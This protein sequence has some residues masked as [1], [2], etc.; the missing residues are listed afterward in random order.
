MAY[1]LWD[2]S[3][4]YIIPGTRTKGTFAQMRI[5]DVNRQTASKQI[6]ALLNKKHARDLRG[7]H[8]F[9]DHF[10]LYN[11]QWKDFVPP[12]R[13]APVPTSEGG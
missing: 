4:S 5:G 1:G 10:A 6:A 13:Q 8:K 12:I 2:V 7:D 11:L 9:S 3:G